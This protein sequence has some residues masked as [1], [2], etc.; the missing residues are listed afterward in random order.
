MT[1]DR[2]SVPSLKRKMLM[3]TEIIED[4]DDVVARAQWDAEKHEETLTELKKLKGI[5]ESLITAK[6]SKDEKAALARSMTEVSFVKGELIFKQGA[7]GDAFYLLVDGTVDVIKDGK[8]KTRLKGTREKAAYFGERAL[9]QKEPR[10]AT[11]KV[12]SV[13]AKALMLDKQSFEMLLGPLEELQRRPKGGKSKLQE[14]PGSALLRKSRFGKIKRKDLKVL[15]LLGCGGFGAVELVEH[16]KTGNTYA[17]K[18]FKDAAA[19]KEHLWELC[20]CFPLYLQQ[21][22]HDGNVLGD[23]A[24]LDASMDLQLVLLT[25]SD[26]MFSVSQ[27]PIWQMLL[28]ET[29]IKWSVVCSKLVL[30]KISALTARQR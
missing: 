14:Q 30:I 11:L 23:G 5:V 10:A 4:L 19:L 25:I 26:G 3:M 8:P 16:E 20:G 13:K 12:Y 28:E 18:D 9:L 22:L 21:L 27:E 29:L 1:G 2:G 7:E 24:E 15:G 17:L 6:V